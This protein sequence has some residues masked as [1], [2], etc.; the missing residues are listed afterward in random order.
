MYNLDSD[1]NCWD[2][3]LS[4]RHSQKTNDDAVEQKKGGDDVQKYAGLL[5]KNI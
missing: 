1:D 4:I 2:Y 3:F 5:G